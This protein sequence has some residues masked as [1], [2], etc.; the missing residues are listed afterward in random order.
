MTRNRKPAL[1]WLVAVTI[2][3][4]ASGVSG[5][6]SKLP[7][8]AKPPQFDSAKFS[9]IFYT[10]VNS[11]LSGSLPSTQSAVQ[12]AGSTSNPSDNSQSAN[13]AASA[14]PL[15][16]KELISPGTLEDLVKGAKLRLDKAISTPAAF[17]G[18]GYNEARRE[19]SLL[20]LVFAIIESYPGEVRWKSSAAAAR[21]AMERT[22]ANTKVGSRQVFDESKKRLQDLE[23]LLGGTAMT[24]EAK[25]DV[26]WEN[27]IDFS[28]LMKILESS[29]DEGLAKLTSSEEIFNQKE[30]QDAI[31]R[32]SE[33]IA[34][35]GRTATFENMPYADDAQFVTLAR[36]MVAQAQQVGL[37][38]RSGNAELARTA[39]GKLGQSC[40]NCHDNYRL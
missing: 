38:V 39:S 29:Y 3:H 14:D 35:L 26:V 1:F 11:A 15:G 7:P 13:T 6:I 36:E 21:A 34:V 25:T 8:R 22:A 9:G 10:D 5:Q 40:T 16:W 28:P 4:I 20:S 33:L 23:S 19:F 32:Y 18:G 12:I 37:A 30:N 27:L 2:S 24:N 31:V 17:A